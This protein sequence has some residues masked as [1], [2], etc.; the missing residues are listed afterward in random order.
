ML[1]GTPSQGTYLLCD[2]TNLNLPFLVTTLWRPTGSTMSLVEKLRSRVD[3][4]WE[5]ASGLLQWQLANSDS[6]A[7]R[8]FQRHR[9]AARGSRAARRATEPHLATA[10]SS[11]A[12]GCQRHQL[13][14]GRIALGVARAAAV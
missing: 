5:P 9:R 12:I 3:I 10:S 8:R 7:P 11:L 1:P 14:N 13:F 2:A 4:E 6:L